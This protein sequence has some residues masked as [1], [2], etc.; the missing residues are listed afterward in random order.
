M[1]AVEF[2]P[3]ERRCAF[4]DLVGPAQLAV[5]LLKLEQTAGLISAHTR[6]LAFINIGLTHP[7]AY[8]FWSV[9]EL[10]GNSFD[11]AVL[12]AQLFT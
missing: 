9:A 6:G 12:R 11:R 8:R 3:E 10:I 5:L 1:L 4:E 7:G 2:R